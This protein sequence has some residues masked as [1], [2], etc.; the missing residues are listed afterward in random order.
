MWMDMQVS[1]CFFLYFDYTFDLFLADDK[2][3][4]SLRPSWVDL[5]LVLG[6]LSLSS[7]L[8]SWL[9]PSLFL[10]GER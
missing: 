3:R 10:S 9:K 7:S 4:R 1:N 6:S 8:L 5:V 2:P